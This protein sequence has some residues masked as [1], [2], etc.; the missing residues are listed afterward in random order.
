MFL[1]NESLLEQSVISLQQEQGQGGEPVRHHR[2]RAP[3]TRCHHLRQ[4]FAR[5]G[6][7]VEECHQARHHYRG[8]LQTAHHPLPQRHTFLVQIHGFHCGLRWR[9]QQIRHPLHPVRV[10]LC[11]AQ[12][13]RQRQG[14]QPLP[15]MPALIL[16]SPSS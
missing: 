15:S 6:V 2:N 10:L 4:R 16:A 11:L 13:E 1:F 5:G 9:E 12:S 3:H 8:C 7:R 14:L